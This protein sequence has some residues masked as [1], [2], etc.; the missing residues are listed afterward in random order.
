M[1]G[2]G[3]AATC[4]V[5]KL[6]VS[7]Y[8]HD[9]GHKKD[10]NMTPGAIAGIVI[11]SLMCLGVCAVVGW[12]FSKKASHPEAVDRSR[13]T[14]PDAAHNHIKFVDTAKPVKSTA[15]EQNLDI[16]AIANKV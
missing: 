6:P 14:G 11:G 9:V 2:E 7:F 15:V 4:A 5:K 1:V 8:A 16:T 13:I 12:K 3:L 10:T